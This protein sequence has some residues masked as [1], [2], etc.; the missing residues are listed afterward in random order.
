MLTTKLGV[1]L[2][3]RGVVAGDRV[4][5]A[6]ADAGLTMRSA[7]TLTQLA[8]GPVNQQTLIDLLGVDPSAVVTVLNE[9]EGRGLVSRQRDPADRRRHIVVMTADG[10]RTLHAVEEVLDK[11]DDDLFAALTPRERDQLERLLTK[12]ADADSCA[13]K[14]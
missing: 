12:V 7:F 3:G 13:E 5:V 10:T 11:T 2:S 1:L 6:L 14:Y 8:E 9:L 4:R